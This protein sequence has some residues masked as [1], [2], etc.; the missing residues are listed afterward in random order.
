M[1]FLRKLVRIYRKFQYSIYG[2]QRYGVLRPGVPCYIEPFKVD[3]NH[4]D[5]VHPCV[6]YIAETY[7]GHCWW[8]V[9]THYY[10]ADAS[11]E[12]PILCYAE[13]NEA[14]PPTQWKVYCEVNK[15]PQD[16]YNSDP[17][18]LYHNGALYVFWRENYEKENRAYYRATFAAKVV[19]GGIEIIDEPLLSTDSAEIDTETC[20]CFMPTSDG[21]VMAYG[22]HLRFHNPIIKRVHPWIKKMLDKIVL[23]LDLLGGYSQQK[24]YGLAIWNQDEKDWLKPYKY[25]ET[26]KFKKCNKLYRPWHMDFFDW[27]GKRYCVVQS[28]QCNADIV[29]AVSGDYKNFTFMRKPLITNDSIEKMGIYKPCAGVLN[30]IFYLYYTAQDKENRSLNKLYLSTIPMSHLL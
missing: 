18:L 24:H 29:L 22:M 23:I 10:G 9:Y 3:I 25:L 5:V 13:S 2:R 1:S 14:E 27:R 28:N 21:G 19:N 20:P 8:L 30:G 4:G 16:G 12:N 7:E 6:R 26:I 17:T 11:M 15:K